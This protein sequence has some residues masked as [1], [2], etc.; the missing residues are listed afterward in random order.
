MP[1]YAVIQS[2][3]ADICPMTNKRVR[4]FAMKSFQG[5]DAL[6]K[7]LGVKVL[8]ELHLDPD[9]KAFILFEAKSAEAVRDYLVQGGYSHFSRL[10]F[11]LVTPI[12]ELLKHADEMPTIY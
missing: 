6:A 8:S 12:S 3:E 11:H 7:K 10:E 9:H 4:E 2:H 1:Q 5:N